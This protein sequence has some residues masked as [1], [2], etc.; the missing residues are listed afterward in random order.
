MDGHSTMNWIHTFLLYCAWEHLFFMCCKK[1]VS[2]QFSYSTAQYHLVLH[3]LQ[4]NIEF[5]CKM[6]KIFS[7]SKAFYHFYDLS[8]IGRYVWHALFRF[9]LSPSRL[10][11]LLKIFSITE[12]AVDLNIFD[13]HL[14]VVIFEY[15]HL[16]SPRSSYSRSYYSFINPTKEK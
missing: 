11:K 7:F 10:L 15:F 14:N 5:V 1:S 3:I 12:I 2:W 13:Y 8:Y 16:K 9:L 6:P 4:E